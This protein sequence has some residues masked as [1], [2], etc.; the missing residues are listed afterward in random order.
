MAFFEDSVFQIQTLTVFVSV[1][2]V[3]VILSSLMTR[4]DLNFDTS[5]II[6]R[7]FC[8]Q[9]IHNEQFLPHRMWTISPE[10][11]EPDF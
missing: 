6:S 7:T 3:F 8:I 10:N 5:A 1:T 9:M 11:L 4:T 2:F